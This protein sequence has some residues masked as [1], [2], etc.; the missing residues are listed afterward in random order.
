MKTLLS[1]LMVCASALATDYQTLTPLD[2]QSYNHNAIHCCFVDW[3]V[4][5]WL[6]QKLVFPEATL[7]SLQRG[8]DVKISELVRERPIVIEMGSLSCPSYLMNHGRMEEVRRKYADKVDFYTVYVRE[9]HPA[10]KAT[11]HRTME[12]K[13][14]LARELVNR[15]SLTHEVLVDTIDGK[16][17]QQLGNFGNSVYVV[18]KDRFV[19]HWSIF[20]NPPLLSEGIESVLAAGGIA[21]RARFVGGVDVHPLVSP[22]YTDMERAKV[23]AFMATLGKE[24]SAKPKG[25]AKRLYSE[26][27]PSAQAVLVEYLATQKRQAAKG[28]VGA[29]ESGLQQLKFLGD[30]SQ[31]FR[32][33][34]RKR[35]A[36]WA[37]KNKIPEEQR[38]EMGRVLGGDFRQAPKK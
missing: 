18:G 4:N 11:E 8:R 14:G 22:E 5:G 33:E 19:A 17:H 28:G 38:L 31:E 3:G 20:A 9:N 29:H 2:A 21:Q 25:I 34:Y 13:K 32:K 15:H 35:Y 36:A 12:Y 24:K 7:Y 10:E 6:D 30:Y 1:A 27:D 16:L 26:M 37:K 23:S